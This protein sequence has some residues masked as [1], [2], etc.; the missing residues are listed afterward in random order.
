MTVTTNVTHRVL[1]G[2]FDFSWGNI[3]EHMVTVY[4]PLEEVYLIPRDSVM[5]STNQYAMFQ[6]THSLG[7][8]LPSS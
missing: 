6:L 7:L 2:Q 8:I 4:L 3:A 1:C 5:C